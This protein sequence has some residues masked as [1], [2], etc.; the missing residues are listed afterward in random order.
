M[1]RND[2]L[3]EPF[4][5]PFLACRAGSGETLLLRCLPDG[6]AGEVR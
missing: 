3:L 1:C 6:T 5:Y 2:P 4:R